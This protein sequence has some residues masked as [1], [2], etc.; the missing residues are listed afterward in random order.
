MGEVHSVQ[1]LHDFTT[2]IFG[3]TPTL[4]DMLFYFHS[5][6]VFSIFTLMLCRCTVAPSAFFRRLSTTLMRVAGPLTTAQQAEAE[7]QRQRLEARARQQQ[8]EEEDALTRREA[9]EEQQLLRRV[10][11]TMPPSLS[12][13][14]VPPIAD[15]L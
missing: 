4:L 6:F 11:T 9:F 1:M 12:P 14:P 7:E 8:R 10:G 2:R 5:V 15:R 3:R 13:V